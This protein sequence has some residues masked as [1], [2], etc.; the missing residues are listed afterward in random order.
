[1]SNPRLSCWR[2]LWVEQGN[3]ARQDAIKDAKDDQ[4]FHHAA[5]RT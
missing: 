3:A 5:L 2:A 4:L 1:M